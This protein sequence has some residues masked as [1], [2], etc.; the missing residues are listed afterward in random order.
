MVVENGVACT[1][2]GEYFPSSDLGGIRPS[3]IVRF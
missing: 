1:G 3:S 2:Y